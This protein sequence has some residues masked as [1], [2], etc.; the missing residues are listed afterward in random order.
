MLFDVCLDYKPSIL[1]KVEQLS[2]MTAANS[3]SIDLKSR[4]DERLTWLEKII[5]LA[6]KEVSTVSSDYLIVRAAIPNTGPVFF[7]CSTSVSKLVLRTS[8]RKMA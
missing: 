4:L 3:I 5:S 6:K 7:R 2:L 1:D 8:A